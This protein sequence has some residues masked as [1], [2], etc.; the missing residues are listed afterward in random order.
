VV[1]KWESENN[2][3]CQRNVR[4]QRGKQL[5]EEKTI[6]R[7]ERITNLKVGLEIKI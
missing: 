5:L 6:L 3:K 2:S 1:I 7:I 4:K